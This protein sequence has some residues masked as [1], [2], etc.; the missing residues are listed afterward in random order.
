MATAAGG[1]GRRA[2]GG[3]RR[4]WRGRDGGRGGGRGKPGGRGGGGRGREGERR[5]KGEKEIPAPHRDAF[6]EGRRE[7]KLRRGRKGGAGAAS[8]ERGAKKTKTF[9]EED[10][11]DGK[12]RF[13][14][15]NNRQKIIREK[16]EERYFPLG[17]NPQR[18]FSPGSKTRK[19]FFPLF[20][21]FLNPVRLK[22]RLKL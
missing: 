4:A 16:I 22:P 19:I 17:E 13:L 2:P 15:E 11:G 20:K 6:G 5:P 12:N 21:F 7:T 8:K 14:F 3:A 18:Y 1:G 10:E 9:G